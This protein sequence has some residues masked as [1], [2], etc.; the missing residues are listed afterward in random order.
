MGLSWTDNAN[1]ET[2]FHVQRS[3]NNVSFTS[4]AAV[5]ANVT[6]YTNTGLTPATTY[7]YRVAAFNASGSSALIQCGK[8][9][10]TALV[11]VEVSVGVE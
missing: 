11:G 8:R 10:D 4:I 6:T 1:N 2:G 5:G 3:T 9:N 7:F